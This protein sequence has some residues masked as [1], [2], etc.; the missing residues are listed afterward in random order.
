M[1]LNRAI[2]KKIQEFQIGKLKKKGCFSKYFF[3]S[4]SLGFI[5][6]NNIQVHSS[7]FGW[8]VCSF[9][10]FLISKNI[11]FQKIEA[12]GKLEK[13]SETMRKYSCISSVIILLL[14]KSCQLFCEGRRFM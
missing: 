10:G 9:V 11:K 5:T 1:S 13:E 14:K 12:S 2:E 3:Q 7:Q 4:N 8:L 6:S